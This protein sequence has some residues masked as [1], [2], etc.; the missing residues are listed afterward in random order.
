MNKLLVITGASRGIGKATAAMFAANGYDVINI[1]RS[2]L[3]LPDQLEVSVSNLAIDLSN[4]NWSNEQGDALKDL[5]VEPRKIVLVHNAALH[6]SDSLQTVAADEFQQ[7][8]QVNVVAPTQLNQLLMPLM[9][10]GSSVLYLGSTLS[11]KA[12]PGACSYVTSKHAVVGL[13]RATCQDTAGSGIH[14]AC[15]CPG[16]TDTEMLRGHIGND[17]A[18]VDEITSNVAFGRLIETEE[19]ATTL[20]FCANNAVINGTILHANLGQ[21]ER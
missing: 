3:E 17:Q 11:E 21:I 7:S 6:Y 15:V 20:Y 19:I 9:T 18:V 2:A 8:L 12:V 5:I 13:M 14:T 16:F 1:S 4:F 10:S